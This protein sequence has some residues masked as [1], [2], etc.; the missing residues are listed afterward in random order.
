MPIDISDME[1]LF[2]W[3][4][5]EREIQFDFESGAYPINPILF[6]IRNLH[7]NR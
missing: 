3:Q 5:K 6:L 2:K 4:R 7:T 1:N